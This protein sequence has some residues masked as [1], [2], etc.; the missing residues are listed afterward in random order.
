MIPTETEGRTTDTG[1]EDVYP[2]MRRRHKRRKLLMTEDRFV[3]LF[4]H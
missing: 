1:L 3:W 2:L 4:L